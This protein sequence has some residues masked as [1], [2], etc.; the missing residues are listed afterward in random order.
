MSKNGKPHQE[1]DLEQLPNGWF[2]TTVDEIAQVGTGTTPKR[3]NTHFWNGGTIPWVTSSAVNELNVTE[4]KEFVTETAL[5]ETN[6]KLYPKNTIIIALYFGCFR[7]VSCLNCLALI[8][9]GVSSDGGEQVRCA[10]DASLVRV[11]YATVYR[12]CLRGG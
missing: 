8:G 3:G 11:G 10:P 1:N 12:I 4:A 6:L 2:W 7:F 5:E 9:Y